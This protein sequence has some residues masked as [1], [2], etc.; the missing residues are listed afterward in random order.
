[1][2]YRT[3]VTVA[4]GSCI[5]SDTVQAAREH[6]GRMAIMRP[7]IKAGDIVRVT[8]TAL[9]QE[10]TL[11]LDNVRIWQET[12]ALRR[13]TCNQ[14]QRW[15][16]GCLPDTELLTLARA[17]LFRPFA[18]MTKRK[19][20]APSAIPHP[21][22]DDTGGSVCFATA[23]NG[24]VPIRWETTTDPP[25]TSQ[26]WDTVGRLRGYLDEV[27]RH[28]WIEPCAGD[29]RIALRAHRGECETCLGTA[30]QH[31]AMVE[32]E[33]AGRELHREYVL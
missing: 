17:E 22:T 13:G 26:E 28:P 12:E 20:L 16:I 11:R 29:A 8:A 30:H 21:I 9:T 23:L 27:R 7:G 3:E 1:M 14:R 33:W 31:T 4:L 24:I 5:E 32:I 10:E 19:R 2:R 25:L 6:A 15:A 18:L